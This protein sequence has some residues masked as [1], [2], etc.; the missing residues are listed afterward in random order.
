MTC[1]MDYN[2]PLSLATLVTTQWVCEQSGRGGKDRGYA[3]AKQHGLPL[4]RLTWLRALLNAHS[5]SSRVPD[6]AP[7]P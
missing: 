4:T 1:C 5:A 2:L 3:W 7:L 6:M